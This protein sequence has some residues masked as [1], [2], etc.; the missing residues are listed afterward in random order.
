MQLVVLAGGL[1]T[2]LRGAIPEGLPKPMAPIGGKPFLEHLL[3]R[4]IT[5]GVNSIHLL[6]GY[7]SHVITEHFGSVYRDVP[8]TYSFEDTPLGTGGALRAAADHLADEFV[9]ANGD[10]FADVDFVK[11]LG[12]LGSGSLSMSLANIDDVGRYGSVVTD[13]DVAIGFREKG[14]TGPGLVNA[15][16]YGCRRA[17]LASFPDRMSFSFETDFLAPQLPTLRPRFQVV[18]S[19]IVDIGT[20]ESYVFANTLV[21]APPASAAD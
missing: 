16:T 4:A 10:T 14:G 18:E 19:G 1:G 11:L 17:L 20:P 8:V 21:K 15:G 5:Q 13:G 9:F 2:R 6:V 7:A 3:D 12:L